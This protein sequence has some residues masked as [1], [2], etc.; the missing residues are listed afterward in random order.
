MSKYILTLINSGKAAVLFVKTS[1][2]DELCSFL[3]S[4]EK[5]LRIGDNF[6]LRATVKRTQAL[7]DLYKY[8]PDLF[9]DSGDLTL[10]QGLTR[11]IILNVQ[12][13][14]IEVVNG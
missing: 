12:V 2:G 1:E 6:H 8:D 14:K 5:L 7:K 4:C 13:N 3:D 11:D 10:G 9:I